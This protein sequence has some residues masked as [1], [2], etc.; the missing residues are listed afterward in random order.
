ML[1]NITG[2]PFLGTTTNTRLSNPW[3]VSRVAVPVK[4][5]KMDC[6]LDE[7][8]FGGW[9][10]PTRFKPRKERHLITSLAG[11]LAEPANPTIFDFVEAETMVQTST[12]GSPGGIRTHTTQILNLLSLPIGILGHISH[13]CFSQLPTI[14]NR[15]EAMN[16]STL[17][18]Q[19]EDDQASSLM[20]PFAH[21]NPIH[22]TRHFSDGLIIILPYFS[23]P[24]LIPCQAL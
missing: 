12:L 20:R 19:G 11:F 18:H 10:E 15:Y 9:L 13:L 7:V 4:V 1:D 16:F 22:L 5:L 6:E 21:I 17:Y 24:V 3:R 2:T 23:Y 8:F 14:S